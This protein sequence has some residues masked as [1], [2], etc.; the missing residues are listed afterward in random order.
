MKLYILCESYPYEGGYIHGVFDSKEKALNVLNDDTT[1]HSKRHSFIEE[2][3][4]NELVEID[5]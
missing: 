3:Y 1:V 5:I 4:L 2:V